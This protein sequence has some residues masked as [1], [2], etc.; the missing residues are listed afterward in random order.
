[1]AGSIVQV[2]KVFYEICQWK[3]WNDSEF[4]ECVR[5]NSVTLIKTVTKTKF[6]YTD[7]NSYQTKIQLLSSKQLPN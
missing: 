3:L 6:S 5:M 2:K 7:W 1:M 4:M